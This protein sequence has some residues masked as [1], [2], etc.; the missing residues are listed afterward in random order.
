MAIKH[1][2]DL[3]KAELQDNEVA[4]KFEDPRVKYNFIITVEVSAY[5]EGA[6]LELCLDCLVSILNRNNKRD[7]VARPANQ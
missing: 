1:F 2:C 7:Q 3:C 6:L 4:C 5:K